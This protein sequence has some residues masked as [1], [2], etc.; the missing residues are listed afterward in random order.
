MENNFL[1][2]IKKELKRKKNLLEQELKNFAKKDEKLE[3]DWDTKY[4]KFESSASNN[5]EEA[6]DEVEEYSNLLPVE[7]SL[8]TKLVDINKALDKVEKGNYGICEKCGKK[9]A[10]ERLKVSP[11]AKNCLN[12]EK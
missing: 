10:V 8:E 9:I 11:E 7:Y 6:A 12:C 4:P 2:E 5:L 1:E 3:G